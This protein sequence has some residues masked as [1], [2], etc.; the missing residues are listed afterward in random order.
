M[1][2][3]VFNTNNPFEHEYDL[4]SLEHISIYN[5]DF[6]I[7]PRY[8]EHYLHE[9]Y[10]PY[11]ASL[12]RWLI[13]PND[14]FVDVGAHYGFFSILAAKAVKQVKVIAIEP[15]EKN[16]KI[17]KKNFELNNVEGEV[18][19]CVAS[20]T[21]GSISF[22][23]TN[24][25]DSC[26]VHNHPKATAIKTIIL[27]SNTGDNILNTIHPSIIKIDVEGHE[28]AVLEGLRKTF[29]RVKDLAV[30]LE[31]NPECQ[32]LAG[33]KPEKMLRLMKTLGFHIYFIDEVAKSVERY[34]ENTDTWQDLFEK[35]RYS[36]RYGY[37][38]ILCVR[39]K[40]KQITKDLTKQTLAASKEQ[41]IYEKTFVLNQPIVTSYA[42]NAE[43]IVLH[44]VF[45]KIK[46]GFYV[47]VGAADPVINS[48]TKLFYEIGWKGI[49]IEPLEQM[50]EKYKTE[51][52][53]DFNLNLGIG[54]KNELIPFYECLLIP[55]WSTFS[56][57][58]RRYHTEHGVGFLKRQLEITSLKN[59]FNKYKVPEIN[60][61]KID[62][63][64][65]EREVILGNDW[66]NYRPIVVVVEADN[67]SSWENILLGNGYIFCQFD[68]LNRYY[69]RR[70]NKELKQLLAVPANVHDHYVP[71]RYTINHEGQMGLAA[72]EK[73][74]QA[75][76]AQLASVTSAKTF[77]IWQTYTHLKTSIVSYLKS[78]GDEAR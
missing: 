74:I 14:I 62:V 33:H 51:R 75:L 35:N 52:S 67:V 55:E 60:F 3:K 22:H 7:T 59:I 27:T 15:V 38:N 17:L 39:G 2:S 64:Y 32:L 26:S 49:N 72:K 46:T 21:Q 10:E 57:D 77:R 20:D 58:F 11:T 5:F 16:I 23:I 28:I 65:F 4:D 29:K 61:L 6:L 48:V 34:F 69:L 56:S 19:E 63:E 24:A 13:K 37:I 42:Q 8:R 40:Y 45:E 9:S 12:V 76:T 44:R 71:Y 47:D 43:D 73:Q 31:F 25:S 78:R 36:S 70:E 66:G 54:Q 68:G 41:S 50:W 18:I 53:R 30:I 1:N